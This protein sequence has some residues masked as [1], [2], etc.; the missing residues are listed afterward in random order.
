[1]SKTVDKRELQTSIERTRIA[2]EYFIFSSNLFFI[3]FFVLI[4]GVSFSSVYEM[5]IRPMIEE[6]YCRVSEGSHDAKST[7][8]DDLL[9]NL[10]TKIEK[11]EILVDSLFKVV[12]FQ[13]MTSFKR[14]RN[15]DL[16]FFDVEYLPTSIVDPIL[17]PLLSNH[18]LTFSDYTEDVDVVSGNLEMLRPYFDEEEGFTPED[19]DALTYIRYSDSM[20]GFGVFASE[21]LP[22][23]SLVGEYTGEITLSLASDYMWTYPFELDV[24]DGYVFGLDAK[25]KGNSMRFV[26]HANVTNV[27]VLYV[28]HNNIWKIFYV[29]SEAIPRDTQLFV[30][31]GGAYWNERK[32]FVA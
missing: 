12:D 3:S 10:T 26:N 22:P 24:E 29:T 5:H 6:R 11:L 23:Y 17:E 7:Y 14:Y 31:Y 15:S 19:L 13:V 21:D 8:S 27:D 9:A 28:P 1:M 32:N 25:A 20:R 2:N 16:H 4:V 30:S 18:N